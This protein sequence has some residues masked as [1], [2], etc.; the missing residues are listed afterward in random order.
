MPR[1]CYFA[2]RRSLLSLFAFY[3]SLAMTVPA[4]AQFETRASRELPNEALGLAV[5]DFNHDGKLDVAA[6]GDALWILLGNGDGTFQ[7]PVSYSGVF[8][9]VAVADFN[10]DGNLD[11][12]AGTGG[13][14]VSVFL[15]NGDGTLQ[16]PRTSPTTASCAF[17]VVGDFNGD[18]KMDIALLDHP[19]ISI[20]LGNGDGTFQAPIDNDSFV[21]PGWLAVGDFNND[22]KLDV[23]VVGTFGGSSNLGV[24]LGN[25]DGTLQDSL[26][27]PLSDVPDS[28][29]VGD[30]NR[31]GNLDVAIGGYEVSGITVLLGMGNGHFGATQTYSGAGSLVFVDDFNGDGKL[32]LVAGASVYGAA[33]LLGNGDGTFQQAQVYPSGRGNL[34]AVGDLNGDDRPDLVLLGTIP[35]ETVTSML[36]SGAV[37]FSPSTPLNFPAQLINTVSEPWVTKLTNRGA[38]DISISSLQA[39]NQFRSSS[40][41][42]TSLAVGATCAVS[43]AFEPRSEGTQTGVVKIVDS[44]SSQPQ[45]IQLIGVATTIMMTPTAYNFGTQKV[46]TKSAPQVGSVTNEGGSSVTYRSIGIGGADAKD[47]FETDNCTGRSV[48]P[49]GTCQVNVTFDPTKVG[50]RSAR[51]FVNAQGTASP[52]S[53]P[54]TGTGD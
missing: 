7:S 43:V 52:R 15:G 38:A 53:V 28:V 21:E 11:L 41:C 5:G 10:N 2:L 8:D 50:A 47:F 51:L 18:G 1:P 40:T 35:V 23:A 44:A 45:F 48:P 36:N 17:I 12:V 13:N 37:A 54:L 39:S 14:S 31:D 27:Y 25:G 29:A 30:F 19:Y 22:R 26:T 42:G 4:R 6:V 34:M 16:P 20:L 49:G 33:E 24:L 32:D 9:S 3:C 46:G